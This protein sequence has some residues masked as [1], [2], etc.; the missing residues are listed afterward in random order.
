VVARPLLLRARFSDGAPAQHL[1]SGAPW[2]KCAQGSG[3]RGELPQITAGRSSA[4]NCLSAE[5]HSR[6][7]PHYL[8]YGADRCNDAHS[9]CQH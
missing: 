1:V 6:I 2:R 4:R 9:N 7:D 3:T 8:E 5:N